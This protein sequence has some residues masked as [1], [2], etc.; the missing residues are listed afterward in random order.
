MAKITAAVHKFTSCDGCQL[1]FLT[2][3]E[4]LLALSE[5]IE[6]AHFAE[7][8]PV[9][10]DATVD[11][12]FV[13]GSVS[14]PH[15]I[16]RIETI[17]KNTRFL[18]TIGACATAGG[19]QAL[20]NAANADEWMAGVYTNPKHIDTLVTSLP[21]SN[22]VSV[23]AEIWGCPVNIDQVLAVTKSLLAG[24]KP[25]IKRDAVCV[26]CKRQNNVCVMVSQGIPCMGPVTQLGCGA[27]CPKLGRGCYGCYGPQQNPNTQ[28]LGHLFKHI[29]LSDEQIARHFNH[30]NNQAPAFAK[31]NQTFK[32]I[33][34]THEQKN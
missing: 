31:A 9:N 12:A 33:A 17:R 11:I 3:G 19:L 22:Y 18:I 16:E 25:Q 4:T 2:A 20:R 13:E 32:G 15:E 5:K 6:W 21:I 10:P 26:E 23:D 24:A 28:A 34:I 14:T 27:I 7:A 29:G 8:G 30:I 1:A